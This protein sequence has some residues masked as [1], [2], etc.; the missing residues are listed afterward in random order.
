[1]TLSFRRLG[2]DELD[3]AAALEA[4]HFSHPWGRE[5]FA[6]AL[7][8]EERYLFHAAFDGEKLLGLAGLVLCPPEAE[9]TNVSVAADARRRG[10]AG[11]L[12]KSLLEA[13]RGCGISEFT[14]EVRA[15]NTPAIALYESLG[16]VCEGRRK[17][18]Y[19]DPKEDALIYWLREGKDA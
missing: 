10:I 9:L 1:M 13:G 14:L 7:K 4:S 17:D 18:F 16:F 3:A 8:K 19:R 5:D 2:E 11:R 15:G 12:L 6:D